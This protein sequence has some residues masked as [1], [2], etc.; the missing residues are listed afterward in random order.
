MGLLFFFLFIYSFAEYVLLYI[1][2][3]FSVYA[4]E[5]STRVVE[6]LIGRIPP[7]YEFPS[8]RDF[9]NNLYSLQQLEIILKNT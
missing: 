9:K 2:I 6:S 5:L 7:P 4:N 8:F 3:L 1:N